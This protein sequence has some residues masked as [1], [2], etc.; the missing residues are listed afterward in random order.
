MLACSFSS[1][2]FACK[3]TSDNDGG[4]E[5]N[6]GN[7]G[8]NTPKPVYT[9]TYFTASKDTAA[10]QIPQLKK[11]EGDPISKPTDPSYPGFTF[12]GWYTD[13]GTW[14]NE[15]T[16]FTTMPAQNLTLYA[17][18]EEV[19]DESKVQYENDLNAKS[20]EG[21]LYIHY[22]RFVNTAEEY[23][24]YN[25]WVWPKAYTGIEFDWMRDENG[26]IIVD[27]LGG[28]TCDVD[29]TKKY[30]NAGNEGDTTTY[31]L[32]NYDNAYNDGDIFDKNLYMD[33][34][35][36][37]LIVLESSKEVSATQGGM[38]VS[39]GG[40]QFIPKAKETNTEFADRLRDNGSMHIFAS[41][42]HVYDYQY[43][44]AEVEEMKNPY[45]NDDGTFVSISN[46]DSSGT[47]KYAINGTAG[48]S[49]KGNVVK[50]VG[51][52]IMVSSFAD[53]DG[54]GY[55]D[56]RGIIDNLDYLEALNVDVLWLTPI[57]LSDSYH[58]YD[59]IDYKEVD[60]KFG[61]MDEYK[62][63]LNKAH[64]KGMTVIMDLVLNH[65]SIN[66]VWFQKS[67]QLDPEYRSYYQ[68]K[69]H[70]NTTLSESWHKFG[71]HDYSYYGK[72]ATS[73]PELNYDYQGTR[74][75]IVDV[76]NFWLDI[77][78]DGFRI[79][80]VKHIYMA[81][82]TVAKSTDTIIASTDE[83]T[84]V[85][86][87]SN[88]TKN[89]NFFVEFNAR[90]KEKYPNAYIVGENFDGNAYNVAPYYQGLDSMLN[91]YAY[92]NFAQAM[93]FVAASPQQFS[94]N[95][96]EIAS[97]PSGTNTGSL[98][99]DTW[100]Y[101]GTLYTYHRYR[102]A[103]GVNRKAIDTLFT[104][105]HDVPRLMNNVLG[106]MDSKGAWVAGTVNSSN[107][108]TALGRAKATMATMMTLP[109]VSFIYYGDELGMVSNY[110]QGETST[111]PHIDRKYRQPFKW[112]TKDYDDGGSS[113]ITH[114]SISGDTTYY[115]TWDSYNESLK[116]VN[117][118]DTDSSSMLNYTRYWTNVK[119]NDAV[120]Q[121][122]DYQYIA[123]N[124]GIFAYKLTY[125]NKSYYIYHN[126]TQYS[127]SNYKNGG[128]EIVYGQNEG[129]DNVL[130]A[131]GTVVFR[132]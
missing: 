46:V 17:K 36:G 37:F 39:D 59:I 38:W 118:Q 76:A 14:Q 10:S 121:Y 105:N 82:E 1:L 13:Y 23:E 120:M 57:Q 3:D 30:D 84:G 20:E 114:Y 74:D 48:Y 49:N 123:S 68:W 7:D 28:A 55:G 119:S 66:N 21:H 83:K 45:E 56:I 63:L 116:G 79:D 100:T 64:A 25:L 65:T 132:G 97:P 94:G 72:F 109:G 44:V 91:F 87:S 2:L 99:V 35:V 52:Q 71:E 113:Y 96:Q 11:R 54:D 15:F 29:L 47:S 101:P 75:A 33:P 42:E 69:N 92:Y 93:D 128:G 126:F 22:K 18:W 130:S 80:A 61:T 86:Y 53:G 43:S 107:K 4:N 5:Q 117:E 78:V 90:I 32:K 77:G 108:H 111:S 6:P 58:G 85:D 95:K 124:E 129:N 131:Y 104:S 98:K 31:F 19:S 26:Q 112:T 81:D 24:K 8:S 50:G 122:G 41:Q 106:N 12:M 16:N 115:V 125:K 110:D 73:M 102:S 27:D 127:I 88:V 60:P 40:N 62:E 51:Y 67:S 34:Y 70:T 103:D 9:I 89:I